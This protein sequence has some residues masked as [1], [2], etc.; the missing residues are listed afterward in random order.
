[1][2]YLHRTPLLLTRKQPYVDWANRADGD[3]QMT[4]ELASTPAVY[5]VSDSETEE[6][7]E[8]TLDQVIESRWQEIFEC[9]LAGWVEDEATWPANR[10]LEMFGEWFEVR[11]GHGVFDLDEDEPLTEDDLD[12][13][14]I[15]YAMNVCGWCGTDLSEDRSEVSFRMTDRAWLEERRGRVISVVLDDDHVATGVVPDG[16]EP[17]ASGE[18][19]I[20]FACSHDCEEALNTHVPAALARRRSAN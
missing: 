3:P 16:D 11:M 13:A 20:F 18:D 17:R 4:L 7:Q 12:A 9:E 19:V 5:A 6:G 8:P 1:M 10:S 15:E 14:E 2:A